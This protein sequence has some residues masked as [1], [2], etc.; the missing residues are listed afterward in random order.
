MADTPAFIIAEAGV[1]HDGDLDKAIELV[2]AASK[3]GADAVKFQTFDPDQLAHKRGKTGTPHHRMLSNLALKTDDF[4]ELAMEADRHDI[5][6]MTTPFTILDIRR[7]L[8]LVK[9]LKIASGY[10]L[11]RPF[12][13]AAAKTEKPI[14]I[15]TGDPTYTKGYA[16]YTA[17]GKA[18]DALQKAK[19]TD[20]TL[21]HCIS[22]YPADNP[23]TARISFLQDLF[24][25]PVGYS[26]HDIGPDA[27][28]HA[29]K[30]YGAAVIEK[31]FTLD[32][33]AKGPDHHVSLEPHELKDMIDKIRKIR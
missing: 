27:C 10:L 31:H 15:S 18:I 16:S 1:N 30:E 6:F 25:I 13:Q 22:K 2:K 33:D 26:S 32:K 4:R 3:T 29:A 7:I 24:K 11:D 20:V 8:P 14:I 17:I 12:L 5:E 28:I 21:L 19:A 23:Y 9:R